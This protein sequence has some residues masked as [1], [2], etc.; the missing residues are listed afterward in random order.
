MTGQ[1]INESQ[2]Y[3]KQ[4]DSWAKIYQRP[5]YDHPLVVFVLVQTVNS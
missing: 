5:L 2:K 3:Q 4:V 1:L